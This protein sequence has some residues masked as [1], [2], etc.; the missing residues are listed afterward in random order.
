MDDEPPRGH[1]TE[2]QIELAKSA[3]TYSLLKEN[4]KEAGPQAR[5]SI[6]EGK[7]QDFSWIPWPT[8]Y[9]RFGD[10]KMVQHHE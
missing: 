7:S 8:L 4:E 1:V 10:S 5:E 2:T 9:K 6:R 3:Q